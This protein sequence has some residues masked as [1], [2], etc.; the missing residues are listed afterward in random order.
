MVPVVLLTWRG[1]ATAIVLR[2][3]GALSLHHGRTLEQFDW[4]ALRRIERVEYLGNVRHK[5]V[6][7]DDDRF[8][9]VE[10]EIDGADRLVDTAFQLSGLPRQ[11]PAATP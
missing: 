10:S 2:R 4:S 8:L 11:Q 6:H 9:T 3:G 7:G 1:T 5:L